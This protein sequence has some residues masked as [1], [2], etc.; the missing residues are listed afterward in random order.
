MFLLV[1]FI[2]VYKFG[3]NLNFNLTTRANYAI[4]LAYDQSW[5]IKKKKY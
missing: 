5:I 3:A 2:R 1:D 4:W